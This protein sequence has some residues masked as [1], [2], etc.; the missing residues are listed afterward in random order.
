M[1][2]CFTYI[3]QSLKNRKYYIGSTNNLARRIAE[4]NNG[5]G[6]LYTKI[7]GPW[8]L[9]RYRKFK[10]IDL[11]RKEEKKLKSYKGGNAFKKIITGEMAE[12]SKAARC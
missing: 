4:H 8:E 5:R 11:A 7:N 2:E 10:E 6:G 3:L 9:V 1:S 12:W